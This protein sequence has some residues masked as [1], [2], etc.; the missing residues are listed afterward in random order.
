V[1]ASQDSRLAMMLRLAEWD[2][3]VTGRKIGKGE[4]DSGGRGPGRP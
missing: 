1:K 3:V 2:E 4:G